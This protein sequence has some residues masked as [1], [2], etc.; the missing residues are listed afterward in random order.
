MHLEAFLVHQ[1]VSDMLADKQQWSAK[2]F[3][4]NPIWTDWKLSTWD[5]LPPEM[6][7]ILS[8]LHLPFTWGRWEEEE[9]EKRE[10]FCSKLFASKTFSPERL[11][12]TLYHQKPEYK[13]FRETSSHFAH[14]TSWKVNRMVIIF[15]TC[16]SLEHS[17]HNSSSHHRHTSICA[18]TIKGPTNR[19][20]EKIVDLSMIK[21]NLVSIIH[22]HVGHFS[23][24]TNGW[25]SGPA[26]SHVHVYHFRW[27]VLPLDPQEIFRG[28]QKVRGGKSWKVICRWLWMIMSLTKRS[29]GEA[30][31][32]FTLDIDEWKEQEEEARRVIIQK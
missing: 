23:R 4:S 9:E 1:F 17:F 29:E 3:P 27:T 22:P 25:P 14:L 2:R 24:W 12:S 28:F 13:P 31:W 16:P 15:T 11:S 10:Q 19:G 8:L 7:S 21:T 6:H 30:E 26:R 32:T 20:Q 5:Q 18:H